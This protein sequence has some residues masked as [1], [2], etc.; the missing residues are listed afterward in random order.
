MNLIFALGQLLIFTS[1]ALAHGEDK[2]GPHGGFIRMPGAFHTELVPSGMNKLKVYLLDVNW[3]NPSVTGSSLKLR[4]GLKGELA[5]CEI[6]SGLFYTCEF[7]K[8]I[9]L[10]KKGKLV[11]H[12][13]R[14]NQKGVEVEYDLPLKLA[15]LNNGHKGHH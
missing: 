11:V 6:G 3:K 15:P 8:K 10:G 13:Q 5:K 2:P 14:E 12:S 1:T 4:Y 7:S 9:D